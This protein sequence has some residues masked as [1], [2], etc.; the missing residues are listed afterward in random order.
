MKILRTGHFEHWNLHNRWKFCVV[1]LLFLKTRQNKYLFGI[2]LDIPFLITYTFFSAHAALHTIASDVLNF[3]QGTL[4]LTEA[5][6]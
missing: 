3:D 6:K 1:D 4:S 5:K 2:Y